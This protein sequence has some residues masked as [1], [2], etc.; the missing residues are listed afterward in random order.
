MDFAY[1][2]KVDALRSQLLAFFDAH[3]LP[4]EAQFLQEIADNRRN[5]NVW[6]PVGLVESLKV[7]AREQGLW[8]LFLPESERA[9]QGL[10]NL[11]YAPLCEIMGQVL[12]APEVFNCSA[13]DT[14]NMETLERYGSEA[15]KDRWLEPLLAGNI[16]SAFL[17]TE[18]AV[19]SSDATNIECSIRR[20]GDDY[21][22][23][24]RK[25][26]SS[27]AGDTRCT[28][29][30]VMG[31]TDPAA[32]VHQQ[33]SMI[34]VPADTPGIEV[35]RSLNVFGYDDSKVAGA[36]GFR[37]QSFRQVRVQFRRACHRLRRRRNPAERNHA[38][39]QTSRQIRVLVLDRVV[40]LVE[41]RGL[42]R[43]RRDCD[44]HAMLARFARR[45]L[46][47]DLQHQPVRP[48]VRIAVNVTR[49]RDFFAVDVA[50]DDERFD[51]ALLQLGREIVSRTLVLDLHHDFVA[52]DAR[53]ISVGAAQL[54]FRATG[55][56]GVAASLDRR[57]ADR[58]RAR[59]FRHVAIDAHVAFE[60]AVLRAFPLIGRAVI[61]VA[62]RTGFDGADAL[63]EGGLAFGLAADECREVHALLRVA[64]E[65][66]VAFFEMVQALDRIHPDAG[67]EYRSRR[68]AGD[69]TFDR[70][71]RG[72]HAR[73]IVGERAPV[74]VLSILRGRL[75]MA[76][77]AIRSARNHV[78]VC[79]ARDRIRRRSFQS[80]SGREEQGNGQ[81][82]EGQNLH[83]GSRHIK[84]EGGART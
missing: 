8:N 26:W 76:G 53:G 19:A 60:L 78:E 79:S 43:P 49:A 4:N 57:F 18:P 81:D 20:D 62:G 42:D 65:A 55:E 39:L 15:Q 22:I 38:R 73:F 48:L 59:D 71:A 68:V 24:G 7:K 25:W 74:G 30:I 32:A 36:R 58:D 9:P 5:G 13:P 10:S 6:T 64:R 28:L 27:G 83:S 35:I 80:C 12:W 47:V 67:L 29:Y 52:I 21:V 54:R 14:G 51:R 41:Q 44:R 1:T 46:R 50:H 3:I 31:K 16:R 33:Q 77:R 69:A 11:E 66:I 37:R 56:E 45:N 82:Q 17:M 61:L 34:L 23:N 84:E 2:P 75:G 63:V 40:Q 70:K 72:R